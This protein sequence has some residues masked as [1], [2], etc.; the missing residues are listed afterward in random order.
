MHASFRCTAAFCL[1]LLACPMTHA[2]DH[3]HSHVTSRVFGETSTGET[4]HEFT[5]KNHSG[6][7]IKLITRGAALTS[8][9]VPDRDGEMADV[10]FGFDD[11]EGYESERNMY[12]GCTTGRYAN[13]IAKGRFTLDGETYQLAINNDPNHLHGGDDRSLTRVVW[14]G[15]PVETDHGGGVKFTY[16]SP[17]G[18]ENYPGDLEM[19]VTTTLDDDNRV[20]IEYEATTTKATPVNLTNHAYFNLNGHGSPTINDHVLMINADHYTPV[21]ETLI[22]TG[23]IAEVAGTPLDFTSPTAIGERVDQMGDGEGAGYDHNF[24]LNGEM[25]QM[26]LA[27]EVYSP[28]TGRTLTVTTTEPGVQ[29][30]GGNFLNGGEGKDGATYAYR[31]GLCLET[32]HYPDS[33]NQP[34]FP[35]TILNPSETYTHTCVYDFGVRE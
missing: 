28:K 8:A 22:P 16:T 24:A 15:E 33:P 13:R 20:W 30:Y 9:V 19:T 2:A 27:A 12:F 14:K 10:L 7:S 4:V 5:V 26:H 32:Q 31:S 34:D 29:F 23:E 17:D 1:A 6:A 3:D 35:S 21:D 11:V 18:E 25:G